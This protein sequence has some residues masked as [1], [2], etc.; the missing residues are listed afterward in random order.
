VTEEAA[1]SR[2]P[3]DPGRLADEA[4]ALSAKF[5]AGLRAAEVPIETEPPTAY[6]P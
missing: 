2:D 3:D 6:K 1:D 5:S 4:R